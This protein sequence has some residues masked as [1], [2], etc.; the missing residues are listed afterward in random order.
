MASRSGWWQM[1]QSRLWRREVNFVLGFGLR[2]RSG[3]GGADGELFQGRDWVG[4]SF[5]AFASRFLVSWLRVDGD[6]YGIASF[7]E[8]FHGGFEGWVLVEQVGWPQGLPGRPGRRRGGGAGLRGL[9][10]PGLRLAGGRGCW[11]VRQRAAS[12]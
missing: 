10:W 4:L 8:G 3:S 1:E 7:F 9:R 2:L 6:H 11:H 5:G 12:V